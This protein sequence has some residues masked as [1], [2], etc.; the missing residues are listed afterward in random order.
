METVR[1][2]HSRTLDSG[3]ARLS[4]HADR[5]LNGTVMPGWLVKHDWFCRCIACHRRFACYRSAVYKSGFLE[6]Q[7]CYYYNHFKSSLPYFLE[8][9]LLIHNMMQSNWQFW[10]QTTV[11]STRSKRFISIKT[12][13]YIFHSILLNNLCSAIAWLRPKPGAFYKRHSYEISVF[14]YT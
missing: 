9:S 1:L 7:R 11:Q 10:L 13:F 4:G 3:S 6:R 12:I 5:K 2:C 14:K 8:F